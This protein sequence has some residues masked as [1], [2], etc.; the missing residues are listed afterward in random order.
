MLNY[1]VLLYCDHVKGRGSER[2]ESKDRWERVTW[3][4]INSLGIVSKW[5]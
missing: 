3:S 4:V 2:K 5:D 1:R